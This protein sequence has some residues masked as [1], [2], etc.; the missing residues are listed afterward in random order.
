[1]DFTVLGRTAERC[2]SLYACH[3][4][5]TE[6]HGQERKRMTGEREETKKRAQRKQNWN[7]TGLG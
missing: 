6:I 5:E 2:S 1:M 7:E 4:E 3:V